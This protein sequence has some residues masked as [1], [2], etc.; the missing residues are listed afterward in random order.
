MKRDYEKL[1][2]GIAKMVYRSMYKSNYKP[3][4]SE[5]KIIS[6]RINTANKRALVIA[7][8]DKSRDVGAGQCCVVTFETPISNKDSKLNMKALKLARKK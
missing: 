1:K 8:K 6:S 3:S 4:S 5:V 7:V 2:A